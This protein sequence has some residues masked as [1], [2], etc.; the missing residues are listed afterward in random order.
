M[1]PEGRDKVPWNDQE[2]GTWVLAMLVP[3]SHPSSHWIVVSFLLSKI[4]LDTG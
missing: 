4:K 2:A 1:G 3:I